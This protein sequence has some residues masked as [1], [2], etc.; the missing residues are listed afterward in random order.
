MSTLQAIIIFIVYSIAILNEET[1]DNECFN[2]YQVMCLPCVPLPQTGHTP[3]I[4]AASKGNTDVVKLLIEHKA[5]V[6]I[7]TKVC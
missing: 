6:N 2:L 4:I 3:L 5:I 1:I 7:Q